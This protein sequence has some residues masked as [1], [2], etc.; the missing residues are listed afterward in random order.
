[1]NDREVQLKHQH[2]K[3]FSFHKV[4]TPKSNQA[5]IYQN[6]VAPLVEKVLN[7]YTCT[8]LVYGQSGTGKTYTLFGNVS[9]PTKYGK[10]VGN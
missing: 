9:D 1:M 8:L 6:V 3:R 4:F 2:S 5:V 7:G 10:G